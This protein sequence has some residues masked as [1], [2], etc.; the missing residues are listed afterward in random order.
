MPIFLEPDQ[1]FSIVLD[2]DKDK[3]A[4][5]R[6]TFYVRSLSMREQ[7]KLSAGLDAALEQTTTEGIFTATCELLSQYLVGWS[8]MGSFAYG[9][10]DVQDFLAHHEARELLRKILAN[11]HVQTEEKKS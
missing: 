5:T 6:P 2:S 1:K 11:S 7:V 4:E 3:P 10:A 8:N 9:S